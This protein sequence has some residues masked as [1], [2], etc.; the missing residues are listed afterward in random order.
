MNT[1]QDSKDNEIKFTVRG[2]GLKVESGELGIGSGLRIG[3]GC[4]VES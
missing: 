4:R 3:W 2:G 1:N